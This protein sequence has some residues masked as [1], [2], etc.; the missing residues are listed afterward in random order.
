MA[1]NGGRG[2]V[3]LGVRPKS[4]DRLTTATA[5]SVASSSET[6][7]IAASGYKFKKDEQKGGKVK[8]KKP[9]A[10][11]QR[12]SDMNGRDCEFLLNA[13]VLTAAKGAQDDASSSG[14]S[15][16]IRPEMDDETMASFPGGK[17]REERLET[18]ICKH[19]KDPVLKLTAKDHIAGCLK[20]KQDKARKKKEAREAAAR[21]KERAKRGDD[22]D[23]DDES[24]IKVDS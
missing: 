7:L 3:Q 13:N 12:N 4:S 11:K 18:V 14:S 19:C 22:K 16:P 1:T 23:T 21:A 6:S 2:T 15:S 9:P 17:P 8:L 10:T 20:S 5:S 24:E